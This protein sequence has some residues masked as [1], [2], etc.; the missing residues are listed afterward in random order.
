MRVGFLA[1]LVAAAAGGLYEYEDGTVAFD[2]LHSILTGMNVTV[3]AA[4]SI[5]MVCGLRACFNS[6]LRDTLGQPARWLGLIR[7]LADDVT[8]ALELRTSAGDEPIDGS[9]VLKHLEMEIKHSLLLS[10]REKWNPIHVLR[11]HTCHGVPGGRATHCAVRS[12]WRH[13]RGAKSESKCAK[14]NRLSEQ[15]RE[16]S[17]SR[18]MREMSEP[19]RSILP[20]HAGDGPTDGNISQRGCRHIVRI[21]SR[22]TTMQHERRKLAALGSELTHCA[23]SISEMLQQPQ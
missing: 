20:T 11:A 7:L 15:M 23:E 19:C 13:D 8:R 6:A 17:R 16:M 1:T 10:R 3:A 9:E 5:L 18:Q 2:W 4:S 12:V 22:A 21:H 14:C